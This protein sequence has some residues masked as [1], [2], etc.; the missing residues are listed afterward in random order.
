MTPFSKSKIKNKP[1]AKK[2]KKMLLK[3]SAV[4]AK[5]KK[6]KNEQY[7]IN[8]KFLPS[9]GV[10]KSTPPITESRTLPT[11][12]ESFPSS[13]NKNKLPLNSASLQMKLAPL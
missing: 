3:K 5:K 11:I 8:L 7:N 9:G 12:P 1:S 4:S 10:T 2:I 13:K 6:R